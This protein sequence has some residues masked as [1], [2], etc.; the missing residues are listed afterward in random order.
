MFARRIAWLFSILSFFF[1]FSES[2]SSFYWHIG[3]YHRCTCKYF[4][5]VGSS[6]MFCSSFHCLFYA[7]P[8][9]AIPV[10]SHHFIAFLCPFLLPLYS[11]CLRDLSD[12]RD[13]FSSSKNEITVALKIKTFSSSRPLRP[14]V[15]YLCKVE[16]MQKRLVGIAKCLCVCVAPGYLIG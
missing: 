15:L 16:K 8:C 14:P 10:L 4:M 12:F 11:H 1:T 13:T 5:D 7:M 9:H 2:I 6:N 3:G